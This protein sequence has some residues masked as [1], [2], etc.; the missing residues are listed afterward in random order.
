MIAQTLIAGLFGLAVTASPP[1]PQMPR[2]SMIKSSGSIQCAPGISIGVT[3]G[4]E[5]LELRLPD[6][7][8]GDTGHG[9]TDES[10]VCGMDIEFVQWWYKYRVAI[11]DV[12]YSGRLNL[13]NGV[14][15]YH[16][17]A[18]A[19]FRYIH[20]ENSHPIVQPEVRNLSTAVMVSC[21][22]PF[23]SLS[24]DP[25]PRFRRVSMSLL[26]GGFCEEK[27]QGEDRADHNA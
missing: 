9:R 14:Q 4:P 16:L 8:F 3:F 11:K 15:L 27:A 17:G 25:P 18:F 22:A 7:F 2:V 5:A 1:P 12:T 13:T 10:M 19:D 20:L 24:T 23:K 26:S 6:V 21:P